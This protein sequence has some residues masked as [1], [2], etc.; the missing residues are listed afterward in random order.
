MRRVA[1]QAAPQKWKMPRP[2]SFE[3]TF[4][5]SFVACLGVS[6]GAGFGWRSYMEDC[7]K[8]TIGTRSYTF[9]PWLVSFAVF[10]WT[11]VDVAL[12]YKRVEQVMRLLTR[13]MG[14]YRALYEAL[15]DPQTAAF[16][17]VRVRRTAACAGGMGDLHMQQSVQEMTLSVCAAMVLLLW[18]SARGYGSLTVEAAEKIVGDI[19]GL[20]AG[21][22][23]ADG[24]ADARGPVAVEEN[25]SLALEFGGNA[26]YLPDDFACTMLAAVKRRA[27]I[28]GEGC[29]AVAVP[30][31]PVPPN[32]PAPARPSQMLT[33]TGRRSLDGAIFSLETDVRNYF[34][35]ANVRYVWRWVSIPIAIMGI[36]LPFFIQPVFYSTMGANIVYIGPVICV[37]V[38]GAVLFNVCL[39]DPLASPST[40]HYNALLE[41]VRGIGEWAEGTHSIKFETRLFPTSQ[42]QQI[43]KANADPRFVSRALDACLPANFATGR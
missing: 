12:K 32:T 3:L 33:D 17:A 38:T 8:D 36:L 4:F 27:T 43:L 16:S 21:L 19:V 26:A 15:V 34:A 28:M 42:V 31:P 1:P 40:L 41:Q 14:V 23:V 10:F 22:V 35:D 25:Y 13:F 29:V 37:I 5:L 30:Y 2:R 39:A 18:Q 6:V 11:I 9:I 24:G 20:A 7:C